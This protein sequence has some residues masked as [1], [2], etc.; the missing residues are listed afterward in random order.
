MYSLPT[1]EA[2]VYASG[3]GFTL[4]EL[5]RVAAQSYLGSQNNPWPAQAPR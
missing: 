3:T 4:D 2:A 1:V 5:D